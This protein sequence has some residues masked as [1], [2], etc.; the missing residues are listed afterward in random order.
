[1]VGQQWWVC[2][3]SPVVSC[4]WALLG[5]VAACLAKVSASVLPG[6]PEWPDF[7]EVGSSPVADSSAED[8]RCR[9]ANM[10]VRGMQFDKLPPSLGRPKRHPLWYPPQ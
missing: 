7:E 6:I 1:M 10:L 5:W 2:D 8:Y 9:Q 4:M 3:A